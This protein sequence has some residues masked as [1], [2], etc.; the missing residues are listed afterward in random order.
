MT[1]KY[2]YILFET[3]SPLAIGGNSSELTDKDFIK[4]S[5]GEPFIPATSLTG[6]YRSLFSKEEA[7]KYFGKIIKKTDENEN[8]DKVPVEQSVES[9]IIVYDGVIHKSSKEI[10][11]KVIA[12]GNN[13]LNNKEKSKRKPNFNV[14]DGIKLDKFRNVEEG[15]KYNFEILDPGCEFWTALEYSSDEKDVVEKILSA[16]FSGDIICGGKST[17]GLGRLKVIK[18]KTIIFDLE[19]K[20]ARKDWLD[21]DI[22]DEKCIVDGC[23]NVKWIDLDESSVNNKYVSDDIKIIL[24]LD[25][26]GPLTVREYSTDVSKTDKNGNIIESAADYSQIS[27]KIGDTISAVIPGTAWAGAFRHNMA[28][29]IGTACNNLSLNWENAE[30][31]LEDIFGKVKEKKKEE[32]M[33]SKISFSETYF[34]NGELKKYSRNAIDRFSQGAVDKALHTEK[35]YYGGKDGKLVITIPKGIEDKFIKVL[36]AS[37][38]DLHEGFLAIGGEASVGRGL[39]TIKE[40]A[41]DVNKISEKEENGE[42]IIEFTGKDIYR[43]ILDNYPNGGL[44]D[45]KQ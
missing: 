42:K 41:V 17:R 16:W 22:Y 5:K 29:N 43:F 36:A 35:M 38:A 44:E 40:V 37:V 34:D 39:F 30:I 28:A 45:G 6:K 13:E 23:D 31:L 11:D 8:N 7:E 15:K 1:K 21:F 19:D 33:R 26:A 2:A 4:N 9:S 10:E 20:N 32:S 25:Q 12:E 14:R 24:T 18:I 3:E 27:F